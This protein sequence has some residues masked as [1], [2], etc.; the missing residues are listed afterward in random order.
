MKESTIKKIEELG[1][2]P[3]EFSS[4]S[5]NLEGHIV[6]GDPKCFGKNK[7]NCLF[8]AT[9]GFGCSPEHSGTAVYVTRLSDGVEGRIERY[10]IIAFK[11]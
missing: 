9:G 7:D 8:K 4:D 2:K 10:E 11:K 1:L 5:I 6:L 3:E